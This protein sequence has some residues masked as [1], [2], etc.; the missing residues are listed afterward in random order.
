MRM[1]KITIEVWGFKTSLQVPFTWRNSN[2][3]AFVCTKTG[4]TWLKII[5]MPGAPIF[6]LPWRE[7]SLLSDS[8]LRPLSPVIIPQ[9]QGG[10]LREEFL[11]LTDDL[12]DL[13]EPCLL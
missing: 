11:K 8:V 4:E 10:L 9:L 12:K 7:G 3:K 1:K 2:N 5:S 6:G 13:E